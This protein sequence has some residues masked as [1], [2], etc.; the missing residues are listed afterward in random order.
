MFLSHA[1]IVEPIEMP[2][3]GLTHM[4]PRNIVLDGVQ[5]PPREWAILGGRFGSF[6]SI[7]SLRCTVHSKR[8]QSVVNNGRDHYSVLNNGT[9]YDAAFCQITSDIYFSI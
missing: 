5:I 6:K 9:T 4:G 2:F 3:R 7:G 8:D 1:K